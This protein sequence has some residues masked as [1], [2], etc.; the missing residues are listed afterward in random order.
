ML[1][2]I[3]GVEKLPQTDRSSCDV[4][5]KEA[6]MFY[7]IIRPRVKQKA[8]DADASL[9]AMLGADYM[10]FSVDAARQQ[11]RKGLPDVDL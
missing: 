1:Y 11:L 7:A 8:P 6:E 5:L 4:K 3:Q 10:T 2:E 9:A